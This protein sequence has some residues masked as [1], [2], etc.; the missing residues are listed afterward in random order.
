M[1]HLLAGLCTYDYGTSVSNSFVS[2]LVLN[3]KPLLINH[4]REQETY[5][6]DRNVSLIPQFQ[7]AIQT[8]H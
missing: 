1:V 8:Y 3:L 6:Y 2:I 5:K 7:D 4:F